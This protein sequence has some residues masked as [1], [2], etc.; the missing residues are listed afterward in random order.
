VKVTTDLIETAHDQAVDLK[1]HA[2][3]VHD[4][5]L[6]LLAAIEAA[7]RTVTRELLTEAQEAIEYRMNL[8]AEDVERLQGTLN[9]LED[10]C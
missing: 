8:V 6:G 2:T 9:D 7:G 5:V 4:G 1:A 3:A 10:R